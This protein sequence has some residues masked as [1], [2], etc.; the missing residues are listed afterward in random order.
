MTVYH[1]S[2]QNMTSQSNVV[3]T[4]YLQCVK[5]ENKV[6]AQFVSGRA[7]LEARSV[8]LQISLS[9]NCHKGEN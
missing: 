3:V 9:P 8:L 2:G 5:K 6:R 7:L 1:V 4:H